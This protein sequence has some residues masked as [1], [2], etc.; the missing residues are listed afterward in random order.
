M[1]GFAA[2]NVAR[3][4]RRVR[5]DALSETAHYADTGCSVSPSCFT[6]PL[7][8]CRY[9]MPGGARAVLNVA[10]D[11]EM[12]AAHAGGEPAQFIAERLGVSVRTVFRVLAL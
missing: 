11:A 10:R 6:C 4:A 5:S 1:T 3:R 8:R 2:A 9:D 7:P 12:R